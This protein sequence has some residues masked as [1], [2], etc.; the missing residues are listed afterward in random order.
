M[1]ACVCVRVCVLR[2]STSIVLTF[3]FA[4]ISCFCLAPASNHLNQLLE[5][6]LGGYE[7]LIG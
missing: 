2:G 6:E 7:V 1:C 3:V 5:A 4:L